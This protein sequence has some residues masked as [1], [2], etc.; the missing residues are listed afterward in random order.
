MGTPANEKPSMGEEPP[1]PRQQEH[2]DTL[3]KQRS[4]SEYTWQNTVS[5]DS[6]REVAERS[7]RLDDQITE[8]QAERMASRISQE[9]TRERSDLSLNRSRSRRAVIPEDEFDI[10]SKLPNEKGSV[11]RPPDPPS[12]RLAR[13]MRH[14]HSSFWLVRYFIYI[15][16]I[17]A[18]LV[19][20]VIFGTFIYPGALV[21]GVYLMWF[22][23]WLE[24]IWLSLWAGRVCVLR[25]FG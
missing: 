10:A 1:D 22:S 19:V 11:Y 24:I 13:W 2:L 23:I 7:R 18:L 20:P 25:Y 15:T 12:T 8:L 17:G 21:G 3:E 4:A 9:Q 6:T 14:V 16:P 5:I